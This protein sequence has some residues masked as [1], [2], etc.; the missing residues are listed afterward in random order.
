M[1]TKD[2]RADMSCQRWHQQQQ[3]RAQ[4][5]VIQSLGPLALRAELYVSTMSREPWVTQ[6]HAAGEITL[7][8]DD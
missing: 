3:S 1:E 7:Y 8:H 2:Q 5:P 6:C 4:K